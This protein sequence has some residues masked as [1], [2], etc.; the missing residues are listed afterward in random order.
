MLLFIIYTIYYMY[1]KLKK[2]Y[3]NTGTSLGYLVAGYH[4]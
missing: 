3:K 2:K 4:H 1:Y